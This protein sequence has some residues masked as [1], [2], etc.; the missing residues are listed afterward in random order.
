MARG[1]EETL[2]ILGRQSEE[3]AVLSLETRVGP[4]FCN[5]ME[6]VK[7]TGQ[8]SEKMR[9]GFIQGEGPPWGSK[10]RWATKGPT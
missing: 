6:L 5:N 4:S 1:K 2:E 7:H 8:A 9:V 10:Q 3:L